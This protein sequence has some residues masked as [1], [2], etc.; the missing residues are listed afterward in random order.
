MVDNPGGKVAFPALATT[1]KKRRLTYQDNNPT[2]RAA[3]NKI[4]GEPTEVEGEA[5][6]QKQGGEVAAELLP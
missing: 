3:T 2:E 6:E 1:A 5:T 4:K